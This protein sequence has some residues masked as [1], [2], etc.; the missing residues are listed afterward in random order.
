[1]VVAVVVVV[2]GEG[3]VIADEEAEAEAVVAEGLVVDEAEGKALWKPALQ[4][5]V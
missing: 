5:P 1:M 2:V 3:G 4:T